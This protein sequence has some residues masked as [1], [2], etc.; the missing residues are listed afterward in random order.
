[1]TADET[2]ELVIRAITDVAPDVDP[3]SVRGSDSLRVDLEL[4]SIDFIA[5]LVRLAEE[6]GV[7]VP[8]EDYR[9]LTTVDACAEYLARATSAR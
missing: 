7:E 3:H 2:R 4:D 8:E 1:V 9:Q 5:V 6:T